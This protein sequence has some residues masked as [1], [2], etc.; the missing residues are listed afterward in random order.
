MRIGLPR[1]LIAQISDHVITI[2]QLLRLK[3]YWM[4]LQTLHLS[5]QGRGEKQELTKWKLVKIMSA[6]RMK[7]PDVPVSVQWR[8]FDVFLFSGSF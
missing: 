5:K 2:D 4:K 3:M 7:R 1:S 8:L 6:N